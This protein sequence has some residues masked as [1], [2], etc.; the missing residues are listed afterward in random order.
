MT[1]TDGGGLKRHLPALAVGLIG[2]LLSGMFGVGGGIVL[3][4]LLVGVLRLDRKT[5]H[6]TSLAA[7][8][9]I[10]VSGSI[11]Y[12]AADQLDLGIGVALGMGGVVGAMYGA[13]QLNRMSIPALRTTFA[14]LLVATGLRMVVG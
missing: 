14:I 9:V 4:P 7:V 12:A 6:A 1:G 3:V 5:A 2:G 13:R 11:G 8:F 10:A